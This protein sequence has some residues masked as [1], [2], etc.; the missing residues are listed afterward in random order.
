MKKKKSNLLMMGKKISRILSLFILLQV[1]GFAICRA[2]S[3]TEPKLTVEFEKSTFM[4][5]LDYIKENT[6]YDYM[7]NNEEMK[8]IPLITHS[9][10]NAPVSE[11]LEVCLKDTEYTFV[12]TRNV[13]VIQK[14]QSKAA[15]LEQVT[16][17]GK[18]F[19]EKDLPLPGAAI[20]VKGTHLGVTSDVDGNF[21]LSLPRKDTVRL[22]VSFVGMITKEVTVTDFQKEVIVKMELEVK[23]V[24]EV[25]V[26]GYGNIR[27]SAFT[28]NAVSVTRE[29]LLK[30]SKTNAVAALQV[31]DPSFRI[32]DNNLWGSDPNALPEVRLRGQASIGVKDLDRS[33]VSKSVLRNNPNLPLFIMDGFKVSIERVYDMDPNR[34]ESMTILKD[35]A[36]TAR[37]GAEA[38]NG[39]VVITT[40]APKAGEVQFT[41]NM[42]GILEMPNLHGYNLM[43]AEEKV[44]AEKAAG[45]YDFTDPVSRTLYNEKM[46]LLARGVDTYWLSKPLRNNF[47]HTHSLT[48]EGGSKEMRYGLNFAFDDQKGAMKGSY[49]QG[50]DVSFD[51]RYL[52]EKVQVSNLIRYGVV[53]SHE[54]PYGNFSEYTTLLPYLEYKDADGKYVKSLKDFDL[55]SDRFNPNPLYEAN[56]GNYDKSKYNELTEQFSIRWYIYPTLQLE[57]RLQINQ[58]RDRGDKFTHPESL[59]SEREA[60]DDMSLQ[61]QLS[62][63]DG[64]DVSWQGRV[65]LTYNELVGKHNMNLSAAMD[66]S[67]SKR[68]NNAAVYRGFPSGEFTSISFAKEVVDKP[69]SSDEKRRTLG[70]TLMFNYSY[71]DI[72][73]GDVSV[74]MDGSSEYGS[75]RRFAPFW[76]FGAGINIHNYPFMKNSVISKLKL[77]GS[78]G[79]EGS[80]NFPSYAA[81]PMHEIDISRWYATG[82]GASLMS[83]RG[84]TDLEWQ[85]T[86]LFDVGL[87]LGI[88]ND[89]IYIHPSYY[90]KIT[91]GLVDNVTLPSSTGF[92]TYTS[93]VGKTENKGFEIE[94]R[95]NIINRQDLYLAVFA[96]LAHVT[97]KIKKISDALKAYND[98]VNEYYSDQENDVTRVLTKYEEGQSTTAVY[99]MKSL[100]IDPATGK[101]LYVYKDGT[102]GY[103]WKATEMSVIG[104]KTPKADGSFGLNFRYKG[105]SLFT[106]FTYKF[107]GDFYNTTLISK[108][109]NADFRKNVD[110][111]AME[112]RWQNPGD[113]T[114]YKDIK[115][116][117]VDTKPTS[118]FMQRDNELKWNSLTLEYDFSG[119]KLQKYGINMLRFSVGT[120]DIWRLSTVKTE[121]GTNYPYANSVNF[122][123][124]IGF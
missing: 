25:I 21:S 83:T 44:E 1:F 42:T 72:Y 78:Y 60:G 81:I 111:R 27:R 3:P 110:K 20:V 91:N 113:I 38:A 92:S 57:G 14:R 8:K 9:F 112:L 124:N 37:Y 54:S 18:I 33:S 34:I 50:L 87:E 7:C 52:T 53:K 119:E 106:A 48:V 63:T 49:R 65:S 36:A 71:N 16:I 79:T 47:N 30:V 39:V 109:E 98:K 69:T 62:R 103:E 12:I 99:G 68:E 11:I 84:N 76:A 89:L 26:T 122:T 117:E 93:N 43:N 95:S 55:H 67:T 114:M 70:F 108:V 94:L 121:R 77:R 6:D 5:V 56:I 17:R 15:V 96:N 2:Q 58:R 19:D 123:L 4:Q 23:Q 10:E 115:D 97:N 116:R 40:V 22:L 86:K 46:K 102:V 105:F 88:L 118:R 29:E 28:G 31:F 75:D 35:A 45:L 66:V 64:D 32:I 41:Y 120:T 51:F 90:I 101:E 74:K 80:L 73:L 24:E 100:G 107:G 104:D 13:I 85:K 82:P 61:G 59:Y